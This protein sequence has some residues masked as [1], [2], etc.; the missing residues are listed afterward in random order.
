MIMTTN[1]L[2]IITR[3]TV[4]IH[5]DNDSKEKLGSGVLYTNRKL[6]GLVYVL[7][8]KH[9]LSGLTE[10]EKVSL[11]IYNPE[12][13]IYEY[14][15][16][17]KQQFLLHPV[18]DAGIVVFNQREFATSNIPSVYVIDKTVG[19]DEAVTKGF[20]MASL[21][22]TSEQGESSLVTLHM[23]YLQEV[24][25]ERAFQLSTAD[26]YN[27]DTIKG[28]SGAGIFIETCEELYVNGIFTRFTDEERGKVIYSQRLT[29][30]NE[31]L[32][33]E[34][35]RKMPLAFLGHHG[36][37]QK[38]FKKNVEE[39]VA[40][41]GPRY[42]KKVNVKTGT[43]KYFDCVAKTPE[44]YNRLCREIDV[45]LTEKSYRTRKDSSRIGDFE[46]HLKAIRNDF[47]TA[48]RGLDISV[49]AAID[50]TSLMRRVDDL[51]NELADI[52]HHIYSDYSLLGKKDEQF[53]K[54][55]EA[56][57]SRLREISSDLYSFTEN[58][59]DLKIDLA[60][61]PYLIIKGEAGC[62]KS[63][64]MGD[65]AGKRIE[66]GLP[67][68]LFLGT[69]FTEG[70]YENTITSKIGFLGTY[71]EFLS[72]FNQ[73]GIQVG[74]R[75]LLM[76]DALN[77]GPQALLWKDRLPG[78]IKSLKDYPA[79]GLVV[80]VRDTYFDDVIPDGVESDLKVTI[81]E[82]K[83][84][85]GLEYEAV[86]QF[87][88]AYELNLPNVPI[89]TPEFCNPLF[90]K[91]I[92]DTLEASGEK[93]F[94]KG[95]NGISA[96]FNQYF[97]ELDKKFA[98]KKD[99]YKYRDVVSAAVKLLAFPVFEAEY[100]YLRKQDADTILQHHFPACP[101]LLADLIDNNVLLKTKS[102]FSDDNVDCI[103]FSYQ[104][105]SDFIIAHEIVKKYQNWET[106]AESINTDKALR[107]V[108]IEAQWSFKGILESFAILVPEMFGHEITDIAKFIPKDKIK[109][110][111]F[112]C[113]EF[114]SEALIDSLAWRSIESINKDAIRKF[115]N[116]KKSRVNNDA[117]WYKLVEL[118]VIPNH[119]FNADYFHALMMRGT[120]PQRDGTFQYF[121]NGCAGYDDERCANPMRRLIDWAWSEDISVK[122]DSESTRLAAI[123]LCWLLS[124]TY[125]K[126]RDEATKAL[127]NLLSEQ[128]NVLID[129]MRLFERVDD[130]YI[131]ERMYAVAY[132]VAL[133][134][135]SRDGLT[136]LARY[137]YET[138]FKHNNPP[139]DVLLRDYARNIVEYAKYKVGLNAVDM[140]KVRPP[141][142]SILPIWPTDEELEQYHIDYDAPDFKERK[143]WEQNQIWE[144][145]KGGLADFWNKLAEPHIE[146]FSPI[147]IAEEKEYDK[148]VRLFKGDM[149]KLI[150][151]FS[152][153]K[154]YGIIHPQ[155]ISEKKTLQDTIYETIEN[156]INQMM[157]GEQSKAM[158]QVIIPF[159][160]KTLSL[161]NHHYGQ[162]PTEGVRN[163]L[164][165]RAYDLGFD[166]NLHGNYDR[167]A[168]DWTFRYPDK[169]IDRI[170]KKYQWIAFHEIM[171]ILADNYK[172]KDDYANI[173]SGGY[174]L[175]HGTWQSFLRNINPSMIARVLSDDSKVAD[176]SREEEEQ[177]WFNEEQFN[178]WEFSGS[179]ELWASMT[180]DLPDPVSFIQKMDDDGVEWLTLNN[181]RSWDE[182]KEIGKKKHE[183]KL[184]K[185]DVYLAADAI[186]VK[187]QDKEKAIHSLAG[188][189]LWD[190]V[191]LPTDDFQ[192]LVNREKYWSP[193]YKD[194][195]RDRQGWSDSIDGLDVPYIY[196]CEQACGHIE[197]DRSGTISKYSIPC[198]LLFEGMG[199]E[200]GSHDGQY[201]DKEGNL[202]A[203]SYGYDQILVK[204]EPLLRFLEQNGLTILWIVRGEKRVY[205]SGGIGCQCVYAPCGVYYLDD[206]ENPEGVLNSYKRV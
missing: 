11:R 16:P 127:V 131:S 203:L 94:P 71:Q 4:E 115:L 136:K 80:S 14:H 10:Q 78:F 19:F 25:S 176:D 167:F 120:M 107:E 58:F 133:R 141:Y 112:Q 57:E 177:K 126:H 27:E 74:S 189:I 85:K 31:L 35:K 110:N 179:G 169:R 84:F 180:K 79:I 63:H 152:D 30:F 3:I 60:N 130:M 124:S 145:V 53:K 18:D 72:S 121:F 114:L 38:T 2:D 81:I 61:N 134:T 5:K 105:I 106:F 55:F 48:L 156:G 9:C 42:C 43:A 104:R 202:V 68:L 51:Q 65:V 34:Y 41:L 198:R 160:V 1:S 62:G 49:E 99:E 122:A 32:E 168:K 175:F 103:V 199:M 91:I 102:Q 47:T 151:V 33:K 52:R 163:W 7:T 155:T 190:G 154:A 132:G 174:E 200:Y 6:S 148:A 166:V 98:K 139:K 97:K 87:C 144:S 192:S 39:S 77:E 89:L 95:F 162:F 96:L 88:L 170:G 15:T 111:Y 188:K 159:K 17:V 194:V 70:T 13:N 125:I 26:D 143:G 117:W 29:S 173:G 46:S 140:K 101:N 21:D 92:C 153:K 22:Q 123:T 191:E 54:E 186:L 172:Y 184:L 50:F 157:T 108:I 206:N 119:P 128:V 93:D 146:R 150:N 135:S 137:V 45:W 196:S 197:D 36:L 86:K 161:R 69:D 165:K 142:S 20:P 28:M 56:D 23:R 37:V 178:N 82:H 73:I 113:L 171:G 149:R 164:V 129:T 66:D 183:Y 147:S 64:L 138:I 204:K 12:K 76:I 40:N 182:P 185:H 187:Q 75:A 116:S 205:T 44:Y 83:G 8:A 181:S 100:N 59:K 195:Y 118:S 90:L 67:T 24:T 193:A 158:N 109:R 201:L